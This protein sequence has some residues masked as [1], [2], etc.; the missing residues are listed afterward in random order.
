MW[1]NT[2][3][4]CWLSEAFPLFPVSITEISESITYDISDNLSENL[5]KFS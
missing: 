2:M 4:L 3:A 1:S 5:N